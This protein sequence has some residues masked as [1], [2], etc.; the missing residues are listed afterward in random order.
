MK[1]VFLRD[2]PDYGTQ[3]K[4]KVANAVNVRHILCEKHA[5]ATEALEKI[6]VSYTS[7]ILS[8]QL[9]SQLPKL[10]SVWHCDCRLARDLIE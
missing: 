6:R 4:L 5:R 10:A 1:S 2:S 8:M 9:T 3:A 7:F